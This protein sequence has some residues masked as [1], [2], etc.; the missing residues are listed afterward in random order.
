MRSLHPDPTM[1]F[2]FGDED[3][4]LLS[5]RRHNKDQPQLRMCSPLPHGAPDHLDERRED[6]LEDAARAGLDLDGGGHP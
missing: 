6:E 4:K 5:S 1:Q 2:A 3:A